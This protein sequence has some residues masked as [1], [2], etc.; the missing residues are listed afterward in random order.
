MRRLSTPVDTRQFQPYL[1]DAVPS[2]AQSGPKIE[3]IRSLD[4]G[5]QPSLLHV[6]DGADPIWRAMRSSQSRA[7]EAA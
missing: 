3:V 4:W 6:A 7:I 2:R 1:V 5:R